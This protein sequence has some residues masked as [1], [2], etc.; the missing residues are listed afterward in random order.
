MESS[1]ECYW[2]NAK[3][4]T[5]RR[6]WGQS[7]LLKSHARVWWQSP[8]DHPNP[9]IWDTHCLSFRGF[10]KCSLI[11]FAPAISLFPCLGAVCRWI[12]VA[13]VRIKILSPFSQFDMSPEAPWHYTGWI[14][15]LESRT[16]GSQVAY[17]EVSKTFVLRLPGQ[18]IPLSLSHTHTH[19]IACSPGGTACRGLWAD[20]TGQWIYIPS[21]PP[22]M[23]TYP[24]Y[25][26]YSHTICGGHRQ[27]II[28]KLEQKSSCACIMYAITRP[29]IC[30]HLR[31]PVSP[32]QQCRKP[33]KDHIQ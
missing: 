11:V 21:T 24:I 20:W 3:H 30:S 26:N 32:V 7:L 1:F 9:L 8:I 16:I 23:I 27:Q 6:D 2:L 28:P 10:S 13:E 31:A 5:Q 29:C 18:L 19:A 22:K 15:G 4:T 14:D 25:F 33:I 12:L 17:G